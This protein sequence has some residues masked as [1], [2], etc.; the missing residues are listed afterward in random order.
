MT[1][2]DSVTFQQASGDEPA[3]T[4][5]PIKIE[6]ALYRKPPRLHSGA[7]FF[8]GVPAAVTQHFIEFAVDAH[9]FRNEN[10]C[11]AASPQ[12]RPTACWRARLNSEVLLSRDRKGVVAQ[13]ATF[14]QVIV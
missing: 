12:V 11:T 6:Y 7:Q 8:F 10:D 13:S 5:D 4:G 3:G 9:A 1:G 2:A 14:E